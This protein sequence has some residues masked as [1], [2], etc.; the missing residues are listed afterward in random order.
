MTEG[1]PRAKIITKSNALTKDT[2]VR[3][4][5]EKVVKEASRSKESLSKRDL[6]PSNELLLQINTLKVTV[7][8]VEKEREFYFSKLREIELFIQ[9][10]LEAGLEGEIEAILKNVQGIM[11]KVIHF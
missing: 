7:E 2:T 11:Y 5:K 3:A 1:Q 9:S 4:V 8:Q 10:K 6:T